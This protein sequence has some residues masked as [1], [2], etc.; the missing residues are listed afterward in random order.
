MCLKNGVSVPWAAHSAY[1]VRCDSGPDQEA[2]EGGA[3][4]DRSGWATEPGV[5]SC[6]GK[7]CQQMISR[8]FL[9]AIQ[10]GLQ[11]LPIWLW[12]AVVR[13]HPII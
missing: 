9:R 2:S 1:P 5:L 3:G 10:Q 11:K 12:G 4:I 8:E 6:K 13:M 7:N